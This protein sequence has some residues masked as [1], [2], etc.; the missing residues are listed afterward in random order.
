MRS[1]G[2]PYASRRRSRIVRMRRRSERFQSATAGMAPDHTMPAHMAITEQ[3]RD[4]GD[5]DTFWHE[6][7]APYLYLHGVPT[8]GDDWLPFIERT[9]GYAPDLPGFGR[10]GQPP[11]F[12]YSIPGYTRWLRA[13][14]DA[15]GLDRFSLVVHD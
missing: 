10:S 1:T 13:Y 15:T 14:L 3:R 2:L 9:G 4:V 8:D 11:H 12:D 7:P 6:S 5:V